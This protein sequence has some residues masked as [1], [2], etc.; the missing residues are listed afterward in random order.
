MS[1]LTTIKSNYSSLPFHQQLILKRIWAHLFNLWNIPVPGT[2]YLFDSQGSLLEQENEDSIGEPLN[3]GTKH[4]EFEHLDIDSGV[5]YSEFWDMLRVE[6]PDCHLLRFAKARKFHINK[7]IHMLSKNFKFRHQH[8][9]SKLLNNGEY[10]IFIEKDVYPGVVV[11]LEKQKAVL[12]GQ[13][14]Q[15]RPYILVRPKLHYSKDQTQPE[16]EKYALL[17]IEISR[18]FMKEGSIS[19]L[20]DLTDF[21]LSNMDYTPVKFII[22]CFEAHYPESLG[23]L[24][25]HKAPWLFSP[26]W[27]IIKNW[28]DPVVA[29]KITF[30]KNIKE[31]TKYIDLD[32]L[33]TYLKGENDSINLDKYIPPDGSKDNLLHVR[34]DDGDD[35]D[36]Q[37]KMAV[38]KKRDHLLKKFQD[39]TIQ[40]IQTKDEF[41]SQKLWQLKCEIGEELCQNYVQLDPYIRSRSSYDIIGTLKM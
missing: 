41:E 20:F 1:E 30:T 5:L 19:I 17:I 38:L 35:Y 7:T 10:K 8:Q 21:S 37:R 24:F 40:W 34:E 29:S 18:L 16:L 6:S 4:S 22:S 12:F 32:Q 13:D 39:L 2:S 33:P 14:N 27:N 11:C 9:L 3:V 36:Y 15:G 31:L 26:I 28:L 23:S 25:I